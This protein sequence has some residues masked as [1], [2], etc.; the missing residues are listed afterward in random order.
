M[1]LE[2]ISIPPTPGKVEV[3]MTQAAELPLW[4]QENIK[5]NFAE[6]ELKHGTIVL[7][8]KLDRLTWV[9]AKGLEDNL[10]P[11]FGTIYR[12]YTSQ[13]QIY[14][15]NKKVK[16]VDPLFVTPGA[17][18]FD[19]NT[20]RAQARGS[21]DVVIKSKL[22]GE[23][24][25]LRVR[26]AAMPP[27]FYSN[28]DRKS[29]GFNNA[30]ARIKK[31]NTGIIICR[32]GRQ[33]DTIERINVDDGHGHKGWGSV[34]RL[35][36]NNDRYVGLE[37]DFPADLDEDFTISNTKQGVIVSTRVWARLV[38]EGVVTA[39]RSLRKEY[40]NA[41][42]ETVAK[43]IEDEAKPRLSEIAAKE[44]TEQVRPGKVQPFSQEREEEAK[45][46]FE[47]FFKAEAKQRKIPE[48][49]AKQEAEKEAEE[50]P[51]KVE[52]E[53]L[54][55]APF[56]RIQQRGSVKV[57]KINM[58]HRFYKDIYANN[59]ATAFMRY[60]LEVVLFSIGEGELDGIGNVSK[61]AFYSTEKIEWSK[62]MNVML[63]ILS[64]YIDPDDDQRA[65]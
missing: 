20:K 3:P 47:E 27:G 37:L 8:E 18:Y 11:H 56:F 41:D 63:G 1:T 32:M 60:A 33:I 51:Y 24:C 65:A 61:E 30:R 17:Q 44:G 6:K 29:Q 19:E 7:W 50:R 13:T 22:T 23:P 15:N 39:L 12:N 36:A 25:T 9:T 28:D 43:D 16:P 64:E 52:F 55:D 46:N 26:Y 57:L 2:I 54:P 38:E 40:D 49:Q 10:L 59:S 62:K 31:N 5:K 4:I 14:L 45:R 58:A 53:T 34:G 35:N 42:R 21:V 48:P